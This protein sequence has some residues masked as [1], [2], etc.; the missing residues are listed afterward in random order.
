[1]RQ[2]LVINIKGILFLI[3]GKLDCAIQAILRTLFTNRI[4]KICQFKVW[5]ET[6]YFRKIDIMKKLLKILYW[7]IYIEV[8]YVRTSPHPFWV[9]Q[10]CWGVPKTTHRFG[11]FSRETCRAQH[12]SQ[13]EV[14]PAEGVMVIINGHLSLGKAFLTYILHTQKLKF[15]VWATN[16]FADR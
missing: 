16:P 6:V 14:P 8:N 9:F 10:V 2:P 1:M 4:I 3:E 15:N 12:I 13:K 5:M 7:K 11:G